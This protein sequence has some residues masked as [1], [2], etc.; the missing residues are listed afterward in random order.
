[1]QNSE[2]HLHGTADFTPAG[3]DQADFLILSQ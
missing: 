1:M 3:I 2:Y